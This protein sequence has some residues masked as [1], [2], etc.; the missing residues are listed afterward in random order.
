MTD[1][2]E[3]RLAEINKQLPK[4]A[5]KIASGKK[6]VKVDDIKRAKEAGVKVIIN[7]GLNIA[8]NR[9]SI[10]WGDNYRL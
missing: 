2:E 3:I 6:S 4:P 8:S 9:K 1:D 7:N 5:Q 10:E